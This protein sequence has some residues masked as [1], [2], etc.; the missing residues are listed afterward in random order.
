M[1]AARGGGGKEGGGEHGGRRGAWGN[2][3]GWKGGWRERERGGEPRVKQGTPI[4]CVH[5][6]AR[7]CTERRRTWWARSKRKLDQRCDAAL[8]FPNLK[9][10][11]YCVA[12]VY[13]IR[14]SVSIVREAGRASAWRRRG[15]PRPF[16]GEGGNRGRKAGRHGGG[17]Q[18]SRKAGR[19]AGRLTRSNRRGSARTDLAVQV[20]HGLPTP[21]DRDLLPVPSAFLDSRRCDHAVVTAEGAAESQQQQE[22]GGAPERRHGLP[23]N[24]DRLCG[25]EERRLCVPRL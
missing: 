21:R 18:G 17:R 25:F 9:M 24:R 13:G 15:D 11:P 5:A 2:R 8:R 4:C 14:S 3:R 6:D 1:N 20:L 19:G 10:L 16:R 22:S 23:R 12:Q 7:R